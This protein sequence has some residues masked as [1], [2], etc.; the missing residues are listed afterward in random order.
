MY[1]EEKN[2]YLCRLSVLGSNARGKS[3]PKGQC[4]VLFPGFLVCV[5]WTLHLISQMNWETNDKCCCV[6]LTVSNFLTQDPLRVL[7]FPTKLLSLDPA[8]LTS[9]SSHLFQEAFPI[10]PTVCHLLL[11]PCSLCLCL[12]AI[13]QLAEIKQDLPVLQF[14]VPLGMWAVADRDFCPVSWMIAWIQE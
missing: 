13:Q 11:A 1:E 8:Q 7:R 2:R 4:I 3:R 6:L 5:S 9:F 10:L 14:E 12:S